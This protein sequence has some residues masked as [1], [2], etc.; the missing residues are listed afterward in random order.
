M[1]VIVRCKHKFN[2]TLLN[3]S[4]SIA[5]TEYPFSSV[6]YRCGWKN[7]HLF[8]LLIQL[9]LVLTFGLADKATGVTVSINTVEALP[10]WHVCN[11][12]V[13]L[14][15][16][17]FCLIGARGNLCWLK[18]WVSIDCDTSSVSTTSGKSLCLLTA[19]F[20]CL[21]VKG[22]FGRL[23]VGYVWLAPGDLGSDGLSLLLNESCLLTLK[24]FWAGVV[25]MP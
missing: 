1:Q 21:W 5:W 12:S 23:K 11:T 7:L 9:R 16:R 6:F 13:V 10:S 17:Y 14:D 18:L 8:F 22:G 4:F 19:K 25:V 15:I 24:S 2:Q 20:C 3:S